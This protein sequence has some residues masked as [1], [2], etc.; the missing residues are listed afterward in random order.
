MPG[1][2]NLSMRVVLLF[3]ACLSLCVSSVACQE[4]ASEQAKGGF[5]YHQVVS[6]AIDTLGYDTTQHILFVR[7]ING[8]E[9]YYFEVPREGFENF[10]NAPS[11]GRY[12]NQYIKLHFSNKRLNPPPKNKQRRVEVEGKNYDGWSWVVLKFVQFTQWKARHFPI[13]SC[14]LWRASSISCSYSIVPPS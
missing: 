14:R 9:Y 8:Y 1:H 10:L 13:I 3:V 7:F 11:K 12:F 6:T 5:E 2:K 4:A